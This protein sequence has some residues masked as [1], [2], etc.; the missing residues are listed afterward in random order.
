MS[1]DIN[2][3]YYYKGSDGYYYVDTFEH[4]WIERHVDNQSGPVYCSN[5]EVFGTI[6]QDGRMIFLGYCLNCADYLYNNT[7]GPGFQGFDNIL[8]MRTIE[9]NAPTHLKKYREH[10]LYYINKH[11]DDSV[12]HIQFPDQSEAIPVTSSGGV[13][14]ANHS[15]GDCDCCVDSYDN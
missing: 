10:I 12:F 8:D 9:G 5:C 3:I 14:T 7:R 4:S 2:D 1:D 11:L 15:D 13:V 6:I